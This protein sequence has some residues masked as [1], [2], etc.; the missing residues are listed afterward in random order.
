LLRVLAALGALLLLAISSVPVSAAPN[1]LGLHAKYDVDAS[2]TW[3]TNTFS[4]TS[5]ARVRNVTSESVTKLTFHLLPLRIG[6]LEQ[7]NVTVGDTRVQPRIRDQS[8]VVPLPQALAPGG[9]T[10]VTIGY[11]ATFNTTAGGTRL[12]LLKKDGIITAYRWIPWLSRSQPSQTANFGE[13]WVT[14]VSPRVTVRL[15]SDTSLKFAASGRRTGVDGQTQTFVA[16]DVRDF[17]FSASAKYKVM[18]GSWN[19]VEINVYYRTRSPDALISWTKKALK[20]FSNKIGPYPYGQLNV[21]ETPAGSGMESPALTWVSSTISSAR[22]PYI[23][24]HETAHQ[25]FYGVVG[26]NQAYEPYVDE[27]LA[28]FLARNLL[29]SFRSSQCQTTRLDGSVYDYSGRCYVEVVYVQGGRYLDAYRKDV[30]DAAFWS[31]LSRFYRDH[32]FGLASTRSL[33]TY[34]DAASGA[35]SERH[36]ERFPSAYPV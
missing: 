35:D 23:V 12:F 14:G 18:R 16:N 33:L 10:D 2:I 8:L 7:L 30:G 32:R 3:S 28:D 36:A 20:R 4:V 22:V 26:N 24:V 15:T 9:R 11:R 21:A 1:S 6:R 27:A 17:N 5:T 31:G 29:G 13:T 19:G 25:W 34:L